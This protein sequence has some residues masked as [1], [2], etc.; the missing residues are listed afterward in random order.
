MGALL[1]YDICNR[2]SF[3]HLRHNWVEQIKEFGH[4]KIYLILIGNK[5]DC[6]NDTDKKRAVSIEEGCEFAKE[7]GMS[8]IE[9]SALSGLNVDIAFRRIIYSVGSLLPPVKVHLD[10]LAL[11]VGWIVERRA[12]EKDPV[13]PNGKGVQE[14]LYINYWTGETQTT[15]PTA[16]AKDMLLYSYLRKPAPATPERDSISTTSSDEK[17]DKTKSFGTPVGKIE[18]E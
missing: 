6:V 15:K 13:N 9:V 12:S 11:P 1:V 4:P 2:N 8:Y 5:L 14:C 3:E 18:I 7:I 16:P 17:V 10:H